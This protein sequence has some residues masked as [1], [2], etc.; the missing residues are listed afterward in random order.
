MLNIF[1]TIIEMN[2]KAAIVILLILMVRLFLKNAPKKFSYMLWAVAAFRLCVPYSFK[3]IFSVFNFGG[4]ETISEQI[5]HSVEKIPTYV[6]NVSI[7][8][9]IINS[10]ITNSPAVD[11][12]KPIGSQIVNTVS[13]NSIDWGIFVIQIA[14]VLWIIGF[15]TM[16]AYGIVTYVSTHRRMQNRILSK[17]NIYFSDRIDSPFSM[18]F[19]KPKIY[20]PFGLTDIEQECIIAHEQCHIKRFDHIVKLFSYL[21]LCVHWFN[22]MCWVAFNSMTYDMETSCDE[23]VFA[24][25]ITEEKKKQYSHTLISVGTKKRLPAP[26]PINFDGISNTK[27]RIKNILKFRKTKVWIRVICYA[28]C[29]VVLFACA[30]DVSEGTI[31]DVSSDVSKGTTFIEKTSMPVLLKDTYDYES[32]IDHDV[33]TD[34]RTNV[35]D[36]NLLFEAQEAVTDFKFITIEFH[37]IGTG[38]Y[39]PGEV[40]YSQP[41]LTP[42]GKPILFNT[43]INEVVGDR[44]IQFTDKNG[45][46]R[47]FQICYNMRD[48]G[49]YLAEIEERRENHTYLFKT[50]VATD[51]MIANEN[52]L[53]F[54]DEPSEY[55]NYN[56]YIRPNFNFTNF[57]FFEIDETYPIAI[58]KTLYEIDNL[59]ANDTF[60][61][62]TYYNDVTLSHGFGFI[63]QNGNQ[64]YFAI[65]FDMSGLSEEPLR[66]IEISVPNE[67]INSDVLQLKN[68]RGEVVLD[69]SDVISAVPSY[70]HIDNSENLE[71]CV[72]LTLTEEG[73]IK[74]AEATKEAAKNGTPI[75]IYVNG[76]LLSSP[77]IDSEYAETG[78]V[79]GEAIISG[80]FID[81]EQAQQF[82]D[83]IN[84]A[85]AGK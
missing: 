4:K 66:A 39:G 28:L 27:S 43:C 48:G 76:E 2:I 59:D 71:I 70:Y 10:N 55:N 67:Q 47:T 72:L 12:T 7:D 11:I 33:Y 40:L 29:A 56:V 77:I 21:L 81:F 22:P 14:M 34:V 58:G 36:A 42:E 57:K 23:M 30:A 52:S 75:D 62:S 82:S 60:I 16:L 26:A 24:S 1:N 64:R 85:A 49:Y 41:E 79:G 6:P 53:H 51:E 13:E 61:A 35:H 5:T 80:N 68:D 18:G 63:D 74:F 25:G 8:T 9:P 78:I 65:T 15:A 50:G 54:V 83:H 3:T 37:D 46:L 17:G 84:S 19:I 32:S 44:G 73:A 45:I 69:A 31:D 38:K 20:L